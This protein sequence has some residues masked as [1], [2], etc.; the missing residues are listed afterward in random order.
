MA[1]DLT[2]HSSE[3]IET[4]FETNLQYSHFGIV[5]GRDIHWL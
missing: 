1:F 4:D 5:L 3:D 2:F